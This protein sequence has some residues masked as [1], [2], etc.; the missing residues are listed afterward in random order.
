M[1]LCPPGSGKDEGKKEAMRLDGEGVPGGSQGK[2]SLQL[3]EAETLQDYSLRCG[4]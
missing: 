1:E 3:G 4:G 2:L